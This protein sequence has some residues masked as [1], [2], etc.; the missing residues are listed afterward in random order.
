MMTIRLD[1]K[2]ENTINK[3]AHQLGVSK[4]ELVRKSI[5]EFIDKLDKPSPWERGSDLFGNYA[6]EQAN[7]S[8]DRKALIKEKIRAKR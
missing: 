6:S 1:P 2:L 5:T 7:L 8:S 3:V 4:S